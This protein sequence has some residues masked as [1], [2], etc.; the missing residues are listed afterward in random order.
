MP[1]DSEFKRSLQRRKS[2]QSVRAKVNIDYEY[3]GSDA[4]TMHHFVDKADRS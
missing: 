3:V 1:A 4:G 2:R